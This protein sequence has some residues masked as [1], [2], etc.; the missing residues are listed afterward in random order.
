MAL[1]VRRVPASCVAAHMSPHFRADCCIMQCALRLVRLP[2]AEELVAEN[3]T[4][5]LI[6][7]AFQA[8]GSL[9]IHGVHHVGLLISDLERSL[10]F[11]RDTLGASSLL[12]SACTCLHAAC[13]C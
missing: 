7:R 11:Y 13:L 6:R 9:V 5:L 12:A 2:V 1:R 3:A 8:A 10:K 4:A